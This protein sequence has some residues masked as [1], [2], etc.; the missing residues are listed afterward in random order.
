MAA[1]PNEILEALYYAGSEHT[2]AL[3]YPTQ[4]KKLP[5][6]ILEMFDGIQVEDLAILRTL[7]CWPLN[8][9]YTDKMRGT[10]QRIS[11]T[12]TKEEIHEI[13]Q[14]LFDNKK[15][16]K[17]QGLPAH[18]DSIFPIIKANLFSVKNGTRKIS[19][20][21]YAT[22][23][24]VNTWLY[25]IQGTL[26]E[27]RN[28]KT[29]TPYT[30][31]WKEAHRIECIVR[32]YNPYFKFL[33]T[34]PESEFKNRRLED[35]YA[36]VY[37]YMS[38]LYGLKPGERFYISSEIWGKPIFENIPL[39]YP[40]TKKDLQ[41]LLEYARKKFGVGQY[42]ILPQGK[43]INKIITSIGAV[44]DEATQL[45][46]FRTAAIPIDK[47][48]TLYVENY[49]KP[50]SPA[51]RKTL[52]I[53]LIEYRR[54]GSTGTVEMTLKEFMDY[55]GYTDRK[56]AKEV[57][58]KILNG[59]ELSNIGFEVREKNKPSGRIRLCGG[60]SAYL[61]GKIHWN[62]NVDFLPILE[63]SFITEMPRKYLQTNDKRNPNSYYLYRAIWID[64][65]MNEGKSRRLSVKSL[66][67]KC[68]NLKRN[69]DSKKKG[70]IQQ[71]FIDDMDAIENLYVTY[72]DEKGNPIEDPRSLS[73][74]EFYKCFII[75]DQS[76][77]PRHPEKLK[78]AATGRK[79]QEQAVINARAKA[80][81]KNENTKKEG[82]KPV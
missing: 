62:F 30:E 17:S 69:L 32:L 50:L 4:L 35:L 22:E 55:M 27:I 61:Q 57:I 33:K 11:P 44:E 14:Q 20:A 36:I 8:L 79:K 12:P 26:N 1:K 41:P 15:T 52:D 77:F 18:G 71:R 16:G 2:Q 7:S 72:V 56:Y 45:D 24:E 3:L 63:G 66:I 46:L 5:K 21:L 47:D 78:R 42:H 75:V 10:D 48:F 37:D 34:A 80:I 23:D 54:Q 70:D 81:V 82:G 39:L 9:E 53:F 28:C 6:E 60:T 29:V 31:E 68:P 76:D 19:P 43:A 65:R 58:Q 38:S 51:A 49:E 73:F 59:K 74:K 67:D 25:P 13:C 40:C 64:W